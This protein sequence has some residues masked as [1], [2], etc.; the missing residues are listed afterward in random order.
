MVEAM[1]MSELKNKAY[2]GMCRLELVHFLQPRRD[3]AS[4]ANSALHRK[5]QES[6]LLKGLSNVL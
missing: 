1:E 6:S 5:D 4:H 3:V 2:F